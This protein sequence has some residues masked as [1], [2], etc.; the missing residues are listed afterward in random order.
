MERKLFTEITDIMLK[1]GLK[2]KFVGFEYIREAVEIYLNK[3][4]SEEKLTTE[5]YPKLGYIHG[6][7]SMHIERNIR[8]AIN[9]A[10]K[11]NSLLSINEFYDSIVY[12]NSYALS[13][14]EL[15]SIIIEIINLK[16]I[17]TRIVKD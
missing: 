17:R 13:N 16:K 2:P 14:G 7:N 4:T 15:I 1:L 9:D 10:Y 8:I 12:D 3:D 5:I 11:N 6:V